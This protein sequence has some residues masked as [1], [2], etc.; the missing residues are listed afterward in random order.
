MKYQDGFTLMHEHMTIDLTPGDFGTD[1]FDELAA[2]LRMVYD[3][4]VRNIVDLT[5]QTMGRAPEYVRR[6]SEETGISIFLSTGAYLEAYSGPYIEKRTVGE[7]AEEAIKDLTEGI[8]D[9]GIKAD[10]IGEIAWSQPNE[11]P[12][13]K[14]AWEA[15]CIAARKTDTLVSTHPSMGI[16]QYPQV[17]YLLENGIKPERIVIG[18]IEFCPDDD[19]LKRIL[20]SGVTIGI[21]MIGETGGKGDEF[22]ADFVKKVRDMGRLSQM[23]LSLDI[24]SRNRLRSYGGCGYVHLFETFI[25]M[26]KKRGITDNDVELMLRN[27]PKRLLECSCKPVCVH[28]PD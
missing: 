19:T 10:V 20:D 24:C 22:R 1:S 2:D 15:Y 27:N 9:T 18:H 8:D 4:G 23:T 3:H 13:E 25:P 5:N 26:L 28:S 21:D 7:L 14:K 17:K 11:T 12:L 16:Q 6:L